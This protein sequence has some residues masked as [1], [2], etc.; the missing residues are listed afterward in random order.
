MV[1]FLGSLSASAQYDCA[2][3]AIVLTT[4]GTYTAPDVTGTFL[5]GC[6]NHTTTAPDNVASPSGPI[7]G[8][9]YK[10]TP[11]DTGT[12]TIT[13]DLAQNV[14]PL[15]I[16]TKVQILT[17][18]CGALQC[19]DFADDVNAGANP[20]NYLTTITFPVA[21]GT[22]YYIQWDNFWDGAGFDFDFTFTSST[23]VGVYY[24]NPLTNVASTSATLNWD[25]SVSSPAGYIVEYGPVGF[26]VGTGTVVSTTTNSIT[27]TGLTAST[28]YDY[29][30]KSNCGTGNSSANNP[31]SS[32]RT[33]ISCPFANGLDSNAQLTGWT[34][35]GTGGNGQGLYSAAGAGQSA[36][37]YWGFA[38]GATAMNRFLFTPAFRL[39]AGEQITIS[40]FQR[41]STT[42]RNLR[43]T[44]GNAATI[45]AQTTQIASLPIAAGTTWVQVTTPV[46]T[47]P[48]TGDYYF[49]F[50]DNS[51]A[52]TT[53]TTPPLLRLDT[54]NFTSVLG[55]SDFLSSKFSIFPNPANNVINFSNDTNAVVSLVEMT[56]M[57]GR[58][59]KSA[60][61][62]ATE[63]EISVSDLS[64]GVYMMRITTD[65][66]NATKKIVKQ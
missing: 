59:I 30:V 33:L 35:A 20:P 17:G 52:T 41:A 44:V 49:A 46:Y 37:N 42:A 54:F 10:F 2:T 60:K 13:S 40:F 25:A 66:G 19:Y 63:G 14:A 6:Y 56:D 58:V 23:C 8:L 7:Y 53:S 57:N 61:I 48:T 22:T 62:N 34:I 4:N 1:L 5:S 47:A 21:A 51:S 29:Y 27:L 18:T 31:V 16:D 15:S 50:N 32:F 38:L 12:V 65:Q 26:T 45:A 43:V 39:V 11:T 3:D 55:T 24:N 28:P 9:W 36:P 64:S